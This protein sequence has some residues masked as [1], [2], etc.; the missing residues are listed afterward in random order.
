MF[1]DDIDGVAGG[2]FLEVGPHFPVHQFFAAPRTF[3]VSANTTWAQLLRRKANLRLGTEG[4][5]ADSKIV[6]V[7]IIRFL[8]APSIVDSHR[9]TSRTR[10]CRRP[11]A[12]Q[13]R[14]SM[15]RK[16]CRIRKPVRFGFVV[17]AELLDVF[18]ADPGRDRPLHQP[19]HLLQIPASLRK[20][21]DDLVDPS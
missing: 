6:V 11:P 3:Q 17:G 18:L 19:G 4:Q 10:Y 21:L 5:D 15:M 16:S 2:H 1:V 8:S 13:F 20:R 7:R 14:K 12:C 9:R